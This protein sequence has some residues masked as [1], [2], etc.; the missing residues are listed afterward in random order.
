[1]PKNNKQ[2]IKLPADASV[3]AALARIRKLFYF[4]FFFYD[5]DEWFL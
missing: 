3:E 5:F 4:C 2:V 1:M